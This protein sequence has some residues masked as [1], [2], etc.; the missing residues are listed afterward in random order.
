MPPDH[1]FS[2]PKFQGDSFQKGA[3]FLWSRVGKEG[4]PALSPSVP[5]LIGLHLP[6]PQLPSED[7]RIDVLS[8]PDGKTCPKLGSL[9]G[10]SVCMCERI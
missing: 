5:H 4:V 7:S 6:I 1:R 10:S 3:D 8:F 2:P 9:I